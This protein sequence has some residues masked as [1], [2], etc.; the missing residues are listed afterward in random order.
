MPNVCGKLD[1]TIIKN[2]N[3]SI[4]SLFFGDTLCVTEYNS[5]TKIYTLEKEQLLFF[6]YNF[7]HC[8]ELILIYK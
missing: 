6:V 2:H 8:N 5:K 4:I 3:S 1:E 7:N